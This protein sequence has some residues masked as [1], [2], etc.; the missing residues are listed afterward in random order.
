MLNKYVSIIRALGPL[1]NLVQ[2][3]SLST[4]MI[5]DLF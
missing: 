5:P 3:A 4:L 1:G 2:D